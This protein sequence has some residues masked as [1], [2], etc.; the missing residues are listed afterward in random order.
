MIKTAI[1]SLN[2]KFSWS[3][4]QRIILS[5]LLLML[6]SLTV[7]VINISGLQD[8]QVQFTQYQKVNT[9]TNL[10]LKIDKDVSDLQR[11]TLAFSNIEKNST[12]DQ[13]H[14]LHQQLIADINDLVNSSKASITHTEKI[15]TMKNM[16]SNFGEKIK[17]L[18]SQRDFREDIISTR[19][20]TLFNH[21]E[22][23][24]NL[25]F[26]DLQSIENAPHLSDL[27]KIQKS[28]LVA[29]NLSNKY[30]NKH[31]SKLRSEI[32]IKLTSA[33]ELLIAIK[34]DLKNKSTASLYD[35]LVLTLAQ[36]NQVFHQAVQADRNYLFLV[37]VVIAGDTSELSIL[38]NSLKDEYIIEQIAVVESTQKNIAANIHSAIA[39]S[40]AGSI[41]IILIAILMGRNI[42]APLQSITT[43]FT[44]LAA[45]KSIKEIPG[46]ARRDEI[47][48]LAKAAN[49]FRE[50]NERTNELLNQTKDVTEKLKLREQALEEAVNTAQEA[51]LA[52]SQFLANMSH[53]LRTPMNAILGM[54]SLLQKTTLNLKQS[55]YAKKTESAAKSLLNLLNDILDISKAEAGKM[56][57]DPTPF[58]I[59]HAMKDLSVIMSNNIDNKNVVFKIIIA[60]DL[61]HYFYGDALRLKQILIN[62][63]GNAIKFTEQGEVVIAISSMTKDHK[64]YLNFSVTDTGIGIAAE[65]Q[66][67]IFNGFSQ[68]ESSTTRRFGGTG[69]GLAISQHLVELM[70]G[71]IALDSKV[72]R[73]STFSFSIHLPQLTSEDIAKLTAA[74]KANKTEN[75]ANRLKD[76][77][78]LIVEDNLTNQQIAK[79][80]LELEGAQ[81]QIADNGQEAIDLLTRIMQEKHEPIFDAVL[82][83]LQMPVMDGFQATHIIRHQLDLRN[84]PIIAMTANAMQ[85]DREACLDSGMNDHVG[86][87][88]DIHHLIQ[89]LC[90]QTGRSHSHPI[91][92]ESEDSIFDSMKNQ[93]GLEIDK[94]LAR[95]GGNKELYLRMLPKYFIALNELMPKLHFHLDIGD[96]PSASQ[97]LH[98]LK[99][100]SSTMG[101]SSL[102]RLAEQGEKEFKD[103]IADERVSQLIE[104]ID[105]QVQVSITQITL[106]LPNLP[107]SADTDAD[108][109]NS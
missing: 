65:N 83:D 88:F 16:V 57:L 45:N 47:G 93:E 59:A 74:P 56:E 37:N 9:D 87:P 108:W 12:I 102:S 72:G 39:A 46:V 71:S 10:I 68:A 60:D 21:I 61:P 50:T 30:F 15:D 62:L 13:L 4:K 104:D 7:T 29:E 52:K 67:K 82:M 51:N 23:S 101:F 3:I 86:K 92:S 97:D 90:Q 77:K 89:V 91:S 80:L 58:N 81:T 85:S 75:I 11:A 70:G 64:L 106:L 66:E 96:M 34:E 94:A 17:N 6:I 103:K 32:K 20:P 42:T 48:R 43:T 107:N 63:G 25:I 14:D 99:G 28:I 18:K 100:L 53:E 19:L 40:V 79:E 22:N 26:I 35:D 55:D 2:E 33:V 76:M 84:L 54:L 38:A 44:H 1:N 36:T 78:I 41:I 73:G 31:E 8:F 27:W 95:F 49:V 5:F 109:V 105:T 24:L 98:S 69:L